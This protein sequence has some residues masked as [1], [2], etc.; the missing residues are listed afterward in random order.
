MVGSAEMSG[1]D[2]RWGRWI[3]VGG[4]KGGKQEGSRGSGVGDV[5]AGRRA[6]GWG[7]E[8]EAR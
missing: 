6:E 3:P 8:G 4:R 5:G 7:S 2:V 1:G